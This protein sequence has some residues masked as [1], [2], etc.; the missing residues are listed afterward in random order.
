MMSEDL[1]RLGPPE[2][3]FYPFFG[4]EGSPTKINKKEKSRTLIRTSLLEDLDEHDLCPRQF[5]ALRV[6]KCPIRDKREGLGSDTWPSES[7]LTH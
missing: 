6:E 3:P 4:G 2:V 7:R 5:F 1:I